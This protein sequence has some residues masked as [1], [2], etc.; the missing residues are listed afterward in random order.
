MLFN[1]FLDLTKVLKM[2]YGREI[3]E[4]FFTNNIGMYYDLDNESL[5]SLKKVV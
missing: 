4:K 5:S 2:L 3:A 1:E